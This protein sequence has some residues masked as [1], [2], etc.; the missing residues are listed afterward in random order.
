M[1]FCSPSVNTCR[2]GAG[3]HQEGTNQGFEE[4]PLKGSMP[5]IAA[6]REVTMASWLAR[7]GGHALLVCGD[8]CFWGPAEYSCCSARDHIRPELL[9]L[10]DRRS[11]TGVNGFRRHW[12]IQLVI[13][14]RLTAAWAFVAHGRLQQF[15]CGYE[16]RTNWCGDHF[17]HLQFHLAGDEQWAV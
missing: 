12:D 7:L 14:E 6:V 16:R 3:N 17:G 13:G 5:K 4:R 9:L 8:C 11:A 10:V 2:Q 1:R 15:P